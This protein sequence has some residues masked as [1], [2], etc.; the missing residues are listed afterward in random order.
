MAGQ[1]FTTL[2]DLDYYTGSQASIYIGDVWVD[3]IVSFEYKLVQSKTPLYGYASQLFDDSAAGRVLVQGAF[4]IN[5][6]EQGYLW[7]VLRRYFGT[8]GAETGGKVDKNDSA[9]LMRAPG[10]SNMPD[11]MDSGGQRV[12][13]GGTKISRASIERLTQGEATTGERFNFYNSLAGMS[14]FS[15]DK[16]RDRVFE[17]VVEAFEDEIWSPLATNDGLNLQIRRVDQNHFD[18]FDIYMVFGDYSNPRANH[19]ARKVVGVRLT[20]EGKRVAVGEGNIVEVYD[21]FAQTVV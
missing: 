9:L 10:S 12:G 20:S 7:A 18:G 15:T 5:F 2:Y 11:I 16:S 17:D 21:F 8:T 19:T 3:E 6:K 13:S 14:S 1:E 4:A